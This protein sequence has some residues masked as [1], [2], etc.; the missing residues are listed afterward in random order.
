M[1]VNELI[2]K[3]KKVKASGRGE[4]EVFYFTDEGRDTISVVST[5]DNDAIILF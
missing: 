1:T 3:L 4:Q 2:E 5:E